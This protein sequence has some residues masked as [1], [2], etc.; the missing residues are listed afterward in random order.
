MNWQC[1]HGFQ[2]GYFRWVFL[3]PLWARIAM[4]LCLH[5]NAKENTRERDRYKTALNVSHDVIS[6]PSRV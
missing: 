1:S 4:M 2:P 6:I 5:T 3:F